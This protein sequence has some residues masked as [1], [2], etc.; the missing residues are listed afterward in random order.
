MDDVSTENL[1][2][3]AL[4]ALVED[5]VRHYEII[6]SGRESAHLD[7]WHR[8]ATMVQDI[9]ADLRQQPDVPLPNAHLEG[10][11]RYALAQRATHAAKARKALDAIEQEIT[12]LVGEFRTLL[13]RREKHQSQLWHQYL[14][15]PEFAG[16]QQ[17]VDTLSAEHARLSESHA[18]LARERDEKMPAYERNDFYVYLRK[19]RYGT[20]DYTRSGL[21]RTFDDWLASKINYRENRRNELI[22]RSMPDA[23]NDLVN[24]CA[25]RIQALDQG[26]STSWLSGLNALKSGPD[27]LRFTLLV[28]QIIA[29]KGRAND[30]YD[31]LNIL[32]AEDEEEDEL[33]NDIDQWL[34]EQIDAEDLYQV[35]ETLIER[36]PDDR[37]AFDQHWEALNAV[38][39]HLQTCTEQSEQAMDDYGHAKE[40]EWALRDLRKADNTCE[41]SCN[42]ACHQSDHDHGHE[43]D[44]D[45]EPQCPCMYN[46]ERFYSYPASLDCPDLIT[47]YMK[48][49]LTA[50]DLVEVFDS[51][52]QWFSSIVP[53]QPASTTATPA[54][55]I[56]DQSLTS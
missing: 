21:S 43:D 39:D 9:I 48:R 33:G 44:D 45:I 56:T 2:P 37:Q 30:A 7:A 26:N 46:A 19:R 47:S 32:L 50:A 23:V 49:N 8:Q 5:N 10:E 38:N 40:L 25:S 36:H 17:R 16:Y 29:A 4:Q 28:K 51:Q 54:Q 22:L 3:G 34:D 6:L 41:A 14:E 27:G 11:V 12:R 35:M 20:D 53:E 52:R 18:R 13:A 31:A 42:C 15:N 1:T 55:R 24:Q